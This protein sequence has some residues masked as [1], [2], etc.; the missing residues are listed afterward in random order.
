VSFVAREAV[1][2]GFTPRPSKHRH[3]HGDRHGYSDRS[4]H[5]TSRRHEHGVVAGDAW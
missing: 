3:G 2:D 1:E 5:R 4:G